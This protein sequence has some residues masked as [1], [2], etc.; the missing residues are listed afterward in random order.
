[1]N[2]IYFHRLLMTNNIVD[3]SDMHD[4]TVGDL[5]S[6]IVKHK[7][8]FKFVSSTEY[9]ELTKL[10][11]KDNRIIHLGMDDGFASSLKAAEIC[12]E[13]NIPL[14]VFVSSQVITGYIPWFV[15][16]VAAIAR[17]KSTVCFDGKKYDLSKFE[18]A[19]TLH[20]DIKRDVYQMPQS[21]QMARCCEILDQINLACNG[22]IPEKFR[23]LSDVELKHLSTIAEIG[24]HG[25]T[26]ISLSKLSPSDVKKE[27]HESKANLERVTGNKITCF[28]YPEGLYDKDTVEQVIDAGYEAAFAVTPSY[29]AGI[30]SIK[31][32]FAGR[33]M[34]ELT[35]PPNLIKRLLSK[36]FPGYCQ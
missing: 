17:S 33:G 6:F 2:S 23:F 13:H 20:N 14:T 22:D 25:A 9:A 31:R 32:R 28:S 15:K 12:N 21:E 4:P 1:M 36:S 8:K 11:K 30:Y 10:N 7:K 18:D 26:H 3:Y 29:E 5:N 16:R 34:V 35:D 19:T 24:G 27:L